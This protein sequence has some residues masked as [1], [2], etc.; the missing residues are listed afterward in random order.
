MFTSVFG[1]QCVRTCVNENRQMK[2]CHPITPFILLLKRLRTGKYPHNTIHYTFKTREMYKPNLVYTF[3]HSIFFKFPATVKRQPIT[4]TDINCSQPIRT[5]QT[6]K[7]LMAAHAREFSSLEHGE[8]LKTHRLMVADLR[9]KHLPPS[10]VWRPSWL[11]SVLRGWECLV[12]L[13]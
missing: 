9:R 1:S 4:I 13:F 8:T 12:P 5:Q 10:C 2:L 6:T 3:L 7:C 11:R